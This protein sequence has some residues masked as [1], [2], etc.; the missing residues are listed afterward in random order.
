MPTAQV[1]FTFIPTSK[2]LASKAKLGSQVEDASLSEAEWSKSYPFPHCL[3][4]KL[5][6]STLKLVIHGYPNK[7]LHGSTN[8]PSPPREVLCLPHLV[9]IPTVPADAA[10]YQHAKNFTVQDHQLNI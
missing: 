3:P 1:V 5:I 6:K 10:M 7:L 2:W 4:V 9:H 8:D